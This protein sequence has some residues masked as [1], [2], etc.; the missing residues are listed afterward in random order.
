MWFTGLLMTLFVWLNFQ[1]ASSKVQSETYKVEEVSNKHRRN[2]VYLKF[3]VKNTSYTIFLEKEVAS[4][5]SIS[6]TC[7]M[8]SIPLRKG[9]FG[10]KV[11]DPDRVRCY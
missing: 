7:K 11:F 5:A 3:K 9:L 4:S 2:R 8:V 6:S 1:F 10:I